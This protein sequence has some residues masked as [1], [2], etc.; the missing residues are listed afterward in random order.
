MTTVIT[1]LKPNT[2]YTHSAQPICNINV[3]NCKK[4]DMFAL[5]DFLE[6]KQ[7][8]R[9]SHATWDYSYSNGDIRLKA[10]SY[11]SPDGLTTIV[12]EYLNQ[13]RKDYD[14]TTNKAC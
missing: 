5:A 9:I 7:D 10:K 11:S 1:I 6:S 4:E 12:N 8:L 2:A 13:W 14:E 3:D